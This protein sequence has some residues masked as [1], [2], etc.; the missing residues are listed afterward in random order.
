MDS[1]NYMSGTDKQQG[2][3]KFLFFSKW[4]ARTG[5]PRLDF[6]LS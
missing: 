2:K 5:A 6:S 4:S 3:N 1:Q